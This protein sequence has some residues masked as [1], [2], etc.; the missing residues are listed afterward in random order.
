MGPL[1]PGLSIMPWS[2]G[3]LPSSGSFNKLKGDDLELAISIANGV[4]N[5]CLREGNDRK[6]CEGLA[7]ATALK[8]VKERK[9]KESA[10]VAEAY[11]E[12]AWDNS[13][14]DYTIEQLS[15]A[16]PRAILKWAKAQAKKEDRD[17][18]KDD[19]K[20]RYKEPN[21]DINI[22]GIR[23]ALRRLPQTEDIPQDVLDDAREEL[24]SMLKKAKKALNIE[25]AFD[26]ALSWGVVLSEG[27]IREDDDTVKADVTLI[28]AGWSANNHYY[29]P[30]LLERKASAFNGIGGFAG[31]KK[32]PTVKDYA[33]VF[34]NVHWD[35]K[36][37]SVRGTSVFLDEAVGRL[38]KRA[39]HLV[40]FSI[41]GKGSLRRG[42]AEGRSG[43]I[44]EDIPEIRS[45]DLVVNAAAG[46]QINA[47]L[48]S[49]DET[50]T[51]ESY[52]DINTLSDLKKAYPDLV[53]EFRNEVV[54]SLEDRDKDAEIADLKEQVDAL[55]KAIQEKDDLLAQKEQA[56]E[57]YES[58]DLLEATLA[59]SDLPDASK[60]RIRELFKEAVAEEEKVK[61][62]ID[63]ERDYLNRLKEAGVVTGVKAE[64]DPLEEEVGEDAELLYEVFGGDE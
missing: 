15:R 44:V 17:L 53:E 32:N 38:A 2:K 62:A 24:E 4:L 43:L 25:E 1:A 46:G 61:E 37:K 14:A 19:L 3:N 29:S 30:Y 20:L 13:K 6:K 16:V 33:V 10:S 64:K 35:A 58:R 8:K 45:C 50:K 26:E 36:R 22:E 5:R 60:D 55:K 48:E 47:I 27:D 9:M 49:L 23:A 41:Y 57:V 52:M 28:K 11:V 31:H 59:E 63:K 51:K 21:G 18:T 40:Q 12:K 56:I 54:A 34:E 39:P 42:K 7:I